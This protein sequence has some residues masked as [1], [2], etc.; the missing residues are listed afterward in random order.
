MS[1]TPEDVEAKP[2]VHGL[3][4]FLMCIP[5]IWY[6]HCGQLFTRR[7]LFTEH[8]EEMTKGKACP[9]QKAE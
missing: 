3:H 4:M 1:A 5:G 9:E 7:S 2:V 6:C 8:L